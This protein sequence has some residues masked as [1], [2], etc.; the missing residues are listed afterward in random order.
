MR[1]EH[2]KKV[3]D[4]TKNRKVKNLVFLFFT[5][6]FHDGKNAKFL[7]AKLPERQK[8][9]DNKEIKKYLYKNIYFSSWDKRINMNNYEEW[10]KRYTEAYQIFW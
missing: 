1:W 7:L 4:D 6:K 2:R 8:N 3:Q 10:G 5:H 9:Y